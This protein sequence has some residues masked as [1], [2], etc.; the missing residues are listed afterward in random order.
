[1]LEKLNFHL[2]LGGYV[3]ETWWMGVASA[4]KGGRMRSLLDFNVIIST[5][6]A[7]S[8]LFA[9]RCHSRYLSG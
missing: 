4:K 5:Y 2:S 3:H 9:H 1:M 8:V 7:L 6:W